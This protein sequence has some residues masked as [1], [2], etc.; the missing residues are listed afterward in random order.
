MKINQDD[1]CEDEIIIM[2]RPLT[3][4][5]FINT[6]NVRAKMCQFLKINDLYNKQMNIFL[7]L[8][9]FTTSNYCIIVSK[10]FFF[11]LPKNAFDLL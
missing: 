2:L 3:V 6:F 11:A 9:K 4:E 8:K 7:K 5:F 10:N 1:R